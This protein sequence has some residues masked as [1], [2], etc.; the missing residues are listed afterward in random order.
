MNYYCFDKAF[1]QY[2]RSVYIYN[3]SLKSDLSFYTRLQGI[4]IRIYIK[5]LG[6]LEVII[7]AD[8]HFLGR[9]LMMN[10]GIKSFESIM[11]V[12]QRIRMVKIEFGNM[13]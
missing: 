10:F 7:Q 8:L 6:F 3:Q 11:E 5:A 4:Y 12:Y 13:D 2:M 9:L 1:D